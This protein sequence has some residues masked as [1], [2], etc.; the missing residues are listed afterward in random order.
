MDV[1]YVDVLRDHEHYTPASEGEEGLFPADISPCWCDHMYMGGG[2]YRTP[3]AVVGVS[4]NTGIH[5]LMIRIDSR[6]SSKN[7]IIY[8]SAQYLYYTL[9]TLTI[10]V[11]VFMKR[12]LTRLQ[13]AQFVLGGLASWL[14]VFISYNNPINVPLV[15]TEDKSNIQTSVGLEVGSNV[16]PCM[17]NSG[18]VFALVLGTLYL[19]P[20]IQPFLKFFGRIYKLEAKQKAL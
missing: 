3:Q 20:L 14:Y 12:T 9:T 2:I 8:R 11:P 13:I 1:L 6:T 18:Q 10:K 15:A 19:V 17:N 16:A 7:G 4:F 5:T